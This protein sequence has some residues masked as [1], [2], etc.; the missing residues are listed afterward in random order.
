MQNQF[1]CFPTISTVYII[2]T[3]I[4][5][6]RLVIFSCNLMYCISTR[7]LEDEITIVIL[8][9][10][11]TQLIQLQLLPDHNFSLSCYT[12]LFPAHK[13]IIPLNSTLFIIY[14]IFESIRG[15]TI[16]QIHISILMQTT[17]SLISSS[18]LFRDGHILGFCLQVRTHP[19]FS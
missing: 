16:D 4:S 8:F 13:R 14:R 6:T 7:M 15:K 18:I 11:M 10:F 2:Y 12:R 19:Q 3:T 5:N 17:Y 9:Y 1:L